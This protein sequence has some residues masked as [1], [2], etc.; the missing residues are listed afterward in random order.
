VKLLTAYLLTD[1]NYAAITAHQSKRGSSQEPHDLIRFY[2]GASLCMVIAWHLSVM[3]GYV[4]GIFAPE[5][6]ALEYTIPLSFVAL[7]IPTMK[8]RKYVIVAAF[9]SVVSLLLYEMPLKLGLI[10][11]AL[12]GIALARWLTRD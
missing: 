12:L 7:V 8:N 3:A 6:W 10:V 1:Q 4:F 11:T 9:S 5:S 2:F